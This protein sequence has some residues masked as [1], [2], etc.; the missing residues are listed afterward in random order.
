MN[1]ELAASA[2]RASYLTTLLGEGGK[3]FTAGTISGIAGVV[4]GHPF[5]T[6]KV[7]LQTDARGSQRNALR[8]TLDTVQ[9]EGIR[10]LYKG[11]ATPVAGEAFIN[12]VVFW[13]YGIMQRVQQKHK[14]EVL[15]L[16]QIFAAGMGVGAC[17]AIPVCPVELIKTRLQVQ[18]EAA[19]RRGPPPYTGPL[20]CIRKTIRY[21]GVRGLF[22]GMNATWLRDI[23]SYA[24]YFWSYE[25]TRRYLTSDGASISQLSHLGQLFAGGVGG[26][27]CWTCSFPMDVVKTRLQI[28]EW[29]KV[30][31]QGT[32]VTG[33]RK[34]NG[35]WDCTVQSYRN[36]GLQ[37]FF[38]GFT[39]ALARAFVV[40]AVVFYVYELCVD[41]MNKY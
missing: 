27:A 18:G 9:Q 32:M 35:F 26:M 4:V 20:D 37:V 10:A 25:A 24:F 14:D 8:V 28:Q 3:D 5:D 19:T 34:Y 6:V 15:S 22:R 41:A 36:E 30:D 11:M 16:G 31:M 29:G 12:A 39:P 17:A 21:D 7:R 13:T 33:P 2:P 40:N 23:P 1:A 38:K